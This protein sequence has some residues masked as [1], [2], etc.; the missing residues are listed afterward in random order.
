MLTSQNVILKFK[1]LISLSLG[2]LELLKAE[3]KNGISTS[4]KTIIKQENSQHIQT[5]DEDMVNTLIFS[6]IKNFVG[7]PTMF[8]EKTFEILMNLH[9]RKLTDFRW[10]KDNYLVKIFS[11]PDCKEGLVVCTDPRFKEKLKKDRINKNY[12]KR[13]D[14]SIKCYKRKIKRHYYLSK[15]GRAGH[16]TN[17]CYAKTKINEINISSEL[18]EQIRKNILN[19]DSDSEESISDYQ[20]NDLNVLE[21]TTSDSDSFDVC[22][23]IGKCHYNSVNVITSNSINVL[24][25]N[26]K[27]LLKSLDSIKDKNIQELLIKQII[28]KKEGDTIISN[29]TKLFNLNNI[30]TL[31][32]SGVDMN[33]IQKGI[34]HTHFYKKKTY[35]RLNGAGDSKLISFKTH[36]ILV[37]NL[38]YPLI[39]GT[40][41]IT[42]IYPFSV[43]ENGI[44]TNIFGKDIM[45]I[46][47]EPIQ[48]SNINILNYKTKQAKYLINEINDIHIINQLE[49]KHIQDKITAL[50]SKFKKNVC[51]II[52]NAFW[53]RKEH[54]SFKIKS[55]SH[56]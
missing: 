29:N 7:D 16:T 43:H 38:T 10:Y 48:Y 22:G 51:S 40:S 18:K 4:T 56:E 54:I 55:H 15:C 52:P 8:E 14:Y 36:L 21:H 42:M 37:K 26:D 13:K 1:L 11:R 20:T 39:L 30:T 9:C 27:E 33:F 28:N 17:N 6:I 12:C 34:I 25:H 45:F 46:F 50:K 47:C 41:F 19:S 49:E 24:T 5:L 35:S 53:S 44:K 2:S 23:G 31:I 3:E 32:D